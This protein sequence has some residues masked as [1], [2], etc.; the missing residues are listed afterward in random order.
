MNRQ[1]L[2]MDMPNIYTEVTDIQ[3]MILH[4][5]SL[6]INHQLYLH[7]FHMSSEITLTGYSWAIDGHWPIYNCYGTWRLSW[8][9][10]YCS[11]I[12]NQLYIQCLSPVELW[13]CIRSWRGLIDTTLC[14]KICQWLTTGR[15]FSLVTSVCSTN[16][17]D[18]HDI[19]EVLLKATFKHD[20]SFRVSDSCKK[21]W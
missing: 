19:A 4:I 14:D 2:N 3:G 10:S 7:W 1:T 18:H 16:K 13:V 15:W 5:W 21:R 11:W 17:T 6:Q 20:N 12:C 9:W 8:S